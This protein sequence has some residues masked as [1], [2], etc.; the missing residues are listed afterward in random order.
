MESKMWTQNSLAP[1]MNFSYEPK[2]QYKC[3]K[4]RQKFWSIWHVLFHLIQ[5]HDKDSMKVGWH[6]M[7]GVDV[8]PNDKSFSKNVFADK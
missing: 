6:L 2:Y 3:Y 1:E 8:T 4:E 7:P 5:L